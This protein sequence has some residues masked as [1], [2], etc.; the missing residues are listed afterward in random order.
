MVRFYTQTFNCKAQN[1]VA[2]KARIV[3]QSF[4]SECL[5]ARFSGSLKFCFFEQF[6]LATPKALGL[7]K[8]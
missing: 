7:D 8:Q 6:T 1:I 3:A 4:Y 2:D 5:S